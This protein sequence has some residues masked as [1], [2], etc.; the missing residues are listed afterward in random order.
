MSSTPSTRKSTE[1]Y[2]IGPGITDSDKEITGSKLPTNG[3]ILRTFLY[4]YNKQSVKNIKSKRDA[5]DSVIAQIKPHYEKGGVLLPNDSHVRDK[6]FKFHDNDYVKILLGT[7]KKRRNSE[8]GLKKLKDFKEKLL[9][10]MPLW[11]KNALDH[12]L[13]EDRDFLLSMMG[14]HPTVGYR[15][16]TYTSKD[17]ITEEKFKKRESREKKYAAYL[18]KSKEDQCSSNH[19]K[20]ND[21]LNSD[22]PEMVSLFLLDCEMDTYLVE[23]VI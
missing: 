20:N 11:H 12:C 22:S 8:E 4:Y 17:K 5:A 3:Q 18:N 13:G 21:T 23:Y 7:N 6:I 9:K 10:T 2:G 14:E 16:A 1:I 15:E 19:T